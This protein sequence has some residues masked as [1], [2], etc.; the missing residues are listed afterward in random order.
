MMIKSV[1]Y[2]STFLLF[3]PVIVRA[4]SVAVTSTD[5]NEITAER[6]PSPGDSLFIFLPHESSPSAVDNKLAEQVSRLGVETWLVD[7]FSANFLPVAAS[8]MEKIPA[9][10]FRP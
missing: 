2:L 6:F 4:E 5:G 7:L 9:E 10:Q 8:S 3:M 1:V